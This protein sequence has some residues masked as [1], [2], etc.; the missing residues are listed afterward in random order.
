MYNNQ[1]TTI[2]KILIVENEMAVALNIQAR[3]EEV[4][5]VVSGVAVSGEESIEIAE[6]QLV[7]LVLMDIRLP[8][9]LDGI[10]AAQELRNRF[11]IP[12]VYL[13]AYSEPETIERA[14]LTEPYGYIIKPFEIRELYSVIEIA[15]YKHAQEERLKSREQ[16]LATTLKSIGDAV[17]T[18][19]REGSVTFMNPVAQNLTGWKSEY[20]QGKDLSEVFRIIDERTREVVDNPVVRALI[21][22]K[23]VDLGNH[24]LLIS[25]DGTEIPI[26]DCAAPI[27]NDKEEVTGA[28][29][30][31]HDVIERHQIQDQLQQT[32][33][34]LEGRIAEYTEA[35][36]RANEQLSSEISQRQQVEEELCHSEENFN[37]LAENVD[38]V[39]WI[40]ESDHQRIIYVSPAYEK[41]W[42]STRELLYASEQFWID[43]IH[44]EDRVR[45]LATLP[46]RCREK[47]ECEYRIVQP[48]GTIRWIRDCSF[49]IAREQGEI[50]RIAGIANDITSS[51]LT[52]AEILKTLAIETQLHQRHHR[53]LSLLSQE[54]RTNLST[55]LSSQQILERRRS[56]LSQ[57]K[58]Q[59]QHQRIQDSV[60]RMTQL[61]ENMLLI[62]EA[63]A[64]QIQLEATPIDLVPFCRNLVDNI[65]NSLSSQ[66]TITFISQDDYSNVQMDERLLEQMLKNLLSN[67]IKYSPEGGTVILELVCAESEATFRI[68]DQ[69]LGIPLQ[70]LPKL[71]EPFSRASNVGNI[72]GSGLGLTVVKIIVDL[73]DGQINIESEI[74][75]G[76]TVIVCLPI[77]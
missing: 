27:K 75:A 19:N 60:A 65:E 50:Y 21:S 33:S 71:F 3:L 53:F 66:H 25:K 52:E 41:I 17:I 69:G 15:L 54:L 72:K 42:G 73:H 1:T 64:G 70:D 9:K 39:F 24:T 55:I 7:D 20:A 29:L 26:D 11:N 67:S 74:G 61:L 12:V 62:G 13:T 34:S 10:F 77:A 48:E 31:F 59:E 5:Y 14:K 6:S 56:S 63:E 45:F 22:G 18:T 35:L 47:T 2:P 43:S 8:G 32:N 49:P 46:Q 4:G 76:T 44:P 58:K 51:K 30:V 40:A 37:L 28:V 57:Q 38:S 36:A 16:W 68:Q 23:S